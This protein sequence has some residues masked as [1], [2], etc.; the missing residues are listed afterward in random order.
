MDKLKKVFGVLIL[1][2]AAYFIVVNG[3]MGGGYFS[4]PTQPTLPESAVPADVSPETQLLSAEE[5]AL[6]PDFTLNDL[7]GNEVTLSQFRGQKVVLIVFW[8]KWCKACIEEIPHLI[9][10]HNNTRGQPFEI[11][12]INYKDKESVARR[13]AGAAEIP[14]TVLLDRDG[15]VAK[16]LGVPGLP[17]NILVDV[18][19]K[20]RYF[21]G[22]MPL[23]AE[24]VVK[25]LVAEISNSPT[26]DD[27]TEVSEPA[28]TAA[29]E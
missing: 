17:Q 28:D 15:A 12:G 23:Q 11:L 24:A 16:S 25:L 5:A 21:S 4:A 1:L 20:Q 6:L 3:I 2:M 26:I 29:E 27:S 22:G 9:E 18:N 14:Y 19:G 8:A 10:L 7:Q 13:V